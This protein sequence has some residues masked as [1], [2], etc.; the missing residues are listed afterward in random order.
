MSEKTVK[1][2]GLSITVDKTGES[3]KFTIQGCIDHAN[4]SA[5]KYE[6]EEALSGGQINIILDMLQVE[7]LCSSGVGVILVAYKKAKSAGG[8]LIIEQASEFVMNI[9]SITSLDKM[10]LK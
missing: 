5:L 9:L 4:A 1:N 2:N 6:L 7:Y 8:K 3:V 10:L